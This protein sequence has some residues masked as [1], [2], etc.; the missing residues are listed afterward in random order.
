M[1]TN[2]ASVAK[3]A[4]ATGDGDRHDDL[5]DDTEGTN[6]ERTG[7]VP[8]QG[9]QVTV[10]LEGT[11]AQQVGRVQVSA[12]LLP[13]QNR[14]TAV[15]QFAIEVSTNGLVFNRVF[16]SGPAAFPGDTPRPV[17]P[18]LILRSFDLPST[19]SATH[20]RIVVLENQCTGNTAFQGVQDADP[21]NG[22]DCRDGSPGSLPVV[23]PFELPTAQVVAERDTEVRIA[24]L[25]VFGPAAPPPPVNRPDLTVTDV[26]VRN[27]D[28]SQPTAR[29]TV[30]NIGTA[31]AGASKTE[32]LFD[33]TRVLCLVDT[34]GLAVGAQVTVSCRFSRNGAQGQHTVKATAD[35]ATQVAES[36]EANN[37][38]TETFGFG[39]DDDEEDDD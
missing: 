3:G 19:V 36:N 1:A 35:K 5:I 7:A 27:R 30:R 22:T 37:S 33:G 16:T 8:V 9:S 14:F 31:A 20:V 39:G 26:D 29:A 34:P 38:R 28:S 15:R 25:Q 10:D 11:A 17:A 4:T 23:P 2:R 13:G 24:E 6:W 18:E 21:L 32:L 12:M